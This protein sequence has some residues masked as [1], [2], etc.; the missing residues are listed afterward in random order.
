MTPVELATNQLVG[1]APWVLIFGVGFCLGGLICVVGGV[2]VIRNRYIE[3]V[4][5]GKI[6]AT[7]WAAVFWGAIHTC[8]GIT[9]IILG[10]FFTLVVILTE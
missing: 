4:P 5:D 8:A 7:G 9:L 2:N 3:V 6:T 10:V 1:Q